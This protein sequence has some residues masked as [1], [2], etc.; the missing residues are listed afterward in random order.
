LPLD[1]DD[2]SQ[3]YTEHARALVG[4]FARR[5]YDSE[6]AVEL[7]AETFAAAMTDRGKFRGR[8]QDAAVGWLYGIAR[9]Q[10]AGWLRH[11]RVERRALGRLGLEPPVLSDAELERVDELAGSAGLRADLAAR[12]D[13]LGET[14][15][16]A[17]QLR[18]VDEHPYHEVARR[19]GVSEQTARAR[20]S[21][22]LRTLG[23]GLADPEV[24]RGV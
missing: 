21:R 3:L 17:V 6:V 14:H 11:A 15:R 5:T 20:V 13:G 12:L 10:F 24:S 16:R 2:I 7:M 18:I 23:E 22:G 9:H 19:L 8:D 1:V 4:F